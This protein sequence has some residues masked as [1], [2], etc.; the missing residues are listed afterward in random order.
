MAY[1]WL[2]SNP[3]CI[4]SGF[5][6]VFQLIRFFLLP[7]TNTLDTEIKRLGIFLQKHLFFLI[8]VAFYSR[9]IFRSCG[10]IG[11]FSKPLKFLSMA[12]FWQVWKLW[13]EHTFLVLH[14][15]EHCLSADQ[16]WVEISGLRS[17]SV[18]LCSI[19]RHWEYVQCFF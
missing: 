1:T 18:Y 15:T 14:M 13:S 9:Q 6:A 5:C 16:G 12:N 2:K 11:A 7:N 17:S 19:H 3:C 8:A 10:F 4:I